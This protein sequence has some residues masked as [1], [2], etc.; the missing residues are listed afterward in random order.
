[1]NNDHEEAEQDTDDAR[2]ATG[3]DTLPRAITTTPWVRPPLSNDEVDALPEYYRAH[4]ESG[5][6][7]NGVWDEDMLATQTGEPIPCG[8]GTSFSGNCRRTFRTYIAAAAHFP[9]K[10]SYGNG[11]QTKWMPRCPCINIRETTSPKQCLFAIAGYPCTMEPN[12]TFIYE[13]LKADA[14]IH[15]LQGHG[16]PCGNYRR[17]FATP[18]DAAYHFPTMQ[19]MHTLATSRMRH[20]A[21]T[22]LSLARLHHS[23]T[24][25]APC[26]LLEHQSLSLRPSLCGRDATSSLMLRRDRQSERYHS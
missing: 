24:G 1:M 26:S 15:E 17:L 5:M 6:I 19:R 14:L 25:S 23:L 16:V 20:I 7:K 3:S 8:Y 4:I 12:P 9:E 13:A 11:A 21:I 2:A 22:L 10:L 18:Y